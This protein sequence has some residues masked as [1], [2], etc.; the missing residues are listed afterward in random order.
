MYL[1]CEIVERGVVERQMRDAVVREGDNVRCDIDD[2]LTLSK[3]LHCDVDVSVRLTWRAASE[4]SSRAQQP[5]RS[6]PADR[7]DR[8]NDAFRS[9]FVFVR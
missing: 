2:V 5:S 8:S 1:Q 6:S 4:C 9:V 3:D 7:S